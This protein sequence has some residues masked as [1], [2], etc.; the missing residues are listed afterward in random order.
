MKIST[1]KLQEMVDK[2]K[3]GIGNNKLIPIT[4][5]IQISVNDNILD[6]L[7][8]D[9]RSYVSVETDVISDDFTVVVDADMFV[10]LINKITVETVI[11]EMNENC[12]KITGNGSYKLDIKLDENGTNLRFPED[13]LFK[14]D[15]SQLNCERI[16][17]DTINQVLNINKP[18]LAT[19]LELPCYTGYYFGDNIIA[20]DT[21]KICALNKK[22]FNVPMLISGD[23]L[24]LLKVVSEDVNV[25]ITP[26][27]IV[28]DANDV[29]IYSKPF[30]GIETFAIDAITN[31][32]S[33]NM[34]NVCELQAKQ[35]LS[36]LDRLSLF[37]SPYDKNIVDLHFMSSEV[38]IE[39]K[40]SNGVETLSYLDVDEHKTFDC[41]IDIE[42]LSSQIRALP[43]DTFK[44]YYGDN[45]CIKIECGDVTQIICLAE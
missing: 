10:S 9:G 3:V 2:V 5:Y 28:W 25:F 43:E 24:E 27:G 45:R 11:M 6:L 22:V 23:V 4:Q 33:Q 40:Q 44:L 35:F 20:T 36:A 14:L 13:E 19:T 15:L 16:N 30:E 34:D 21:M 18:A 31:Y 17:K 39:S 37:V 41:H 7:T 32:L 8:T 38:S 1:I 26:E 12:L 42:M 29:T